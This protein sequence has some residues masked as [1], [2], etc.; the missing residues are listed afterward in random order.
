V[1]ARG[2]DDESVDGHRAPPA[3]QQGLGE[4]WRCPLVRVQSLRSWCGPVL[5]INHLAPQITSVETRREVRDD[6]VTVS[7][8]LERSEALRSIDRLPFAAR[9]Y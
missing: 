8:A 6:V 4:H 3:W 9:S 1:R 5:P 7:T 2:H